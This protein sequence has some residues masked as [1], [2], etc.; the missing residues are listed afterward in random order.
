MFV[1]F[2]HLY[3]DV[4][5]H[6]YG[7]NLEDIQKKLTPYFPEEQL[8][9]IESAFETKAMIH[10]NSGTDNNEDSLM[11]AI[12]FGEKYRTDR[13]RMIAITK[14]IIKNKGVFKP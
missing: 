8:E 3:D 4:E 9:M 7:Y 11:P 12:M 14:N 10:Y 5:F 13:G 6:S 2:A 1:S